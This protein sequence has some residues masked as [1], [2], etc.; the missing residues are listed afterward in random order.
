[1]SKRFLAILLTLA[2][3]CMFALPSS[4]VPILDPPT[5]VITPLE[6]PGIAT[7]DGYIDDKWV[8]F[9]FDYKT[10]LITFWMDSNLVEKNKNHTLKVVVKDNCGN[11]AEYNTQFYW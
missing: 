10:R 9:E 7:Y 6:T 4:A 5:P 8:M 2:L 11:E 3:V 1:M